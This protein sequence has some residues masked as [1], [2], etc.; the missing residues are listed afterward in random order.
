MKKRV[1]GLFACLLV[2][3]FIASPVVA[4]AADYTNPETVQPQPANTTGTL[5]IHKYALTNDLMPGQNDDTT[6]TNDL[7]PTS[8]YS[9]T[10]L[11]DIIFNVYPVSPIQTGPDPYGNY[12]DQYPTSPITLAMLD[13]YTSPTVITQ[14]GVP[15]PLGAAQPITTD[16]AGL[17]TLSGLN[18]VFLVIEQKD[19][20]VAEPAAP[21]LVAVPMT[22]PTGDG[23]L[24]VVDVYP[25]N[26]TLNIAKAADRGAYNVGDTVTY[27]ITADVPTTINTA[28]AYSITD[29]LDPALTYADVAV[30]A[31]TT[32]NVD[33]TLGT[34][35]A[36]L[37]AGTDYTVDTSG[38]TIALTSAGMQKLAQG[39]GADPYL[40]LQ[41][42]LSTTL[43]KTV[44]NY[45]DTSTAMSKPQDSTTMVAALPNYT[46]PN[47]AQINFTNQYDEA[48]TVVSNEVD[49]NTA[50]IDITK[51]DAATANDAT[52]TKL[53]DAEFKIATSSDNAQNQHFLKTDSA[54]NLYDYWDG[55]L[56]APTDHLYYT[57]DGATV[58]PGGLKDYVVTTDSSGN[59]SLE[60][61]ADYNGFVTADSSS[62]ATT[63]SA[64]W[65]SYYLV[66]TKAPANYNLVPG[67]ITVT[68]DASMSAG[69]AA[70]HIASVTVTNN[71][72]FML[73]KTGGAGTILFTVGGIVIIGMA[74]ILLLG[75]K[76]KKRTP[77]SK[78]L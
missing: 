68:F 9:N 34:P 62:G 70:T 23:W 44:L 72:G 35:Q 22:N 46:V 42:T 17:A 28:K 21:F 73:P 16:A 61:I 41:T 57:D 77:P 56:P 27:T 51:I 10:P 33:G 6:G 29:P 48:K 36:M 13:S 71:H 2:L 5:N 63:Y 49:I 50:V 30:V 47:N 66:E 55:V 14:N 11:K 67:I 60:G 45:T 64:D 24:T 74:V 54:G 59:A 32:K 76:K 7:A 12:S 15:F 8:P 38:V 39:D 18:G 53:P 52:P 58:A 78:N 65:L 26:E 1:L 3:C 69:S 20:R 40:Y 31:A 4:L 25:K 19:P 43:N 75:S 37:T